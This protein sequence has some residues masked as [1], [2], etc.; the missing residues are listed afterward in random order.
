MNEIDKVLGR[1]FNLVKNVLVLCKLWKRGS[2]IPAPVRDFFPRLFGVCVRVRNILDRNKRGKNFAPSTMLVIAIVMV[3]H[4]IKK[5]M[6][7]F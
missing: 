2:Q 6:D 5:N 4:G 7:D 1:G 3:W